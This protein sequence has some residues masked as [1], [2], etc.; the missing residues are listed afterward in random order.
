VDQ[1]SRC[2]PGPTSVKESGL[3][4]RMLE[5]ARTSGCTEVRLL[6]ERNNAPAVALYESLG[7]VEGDPD[8]TIFTFKP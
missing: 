3:V 1:R 2:R 4:R 8:S 6:T 7:G 5:D